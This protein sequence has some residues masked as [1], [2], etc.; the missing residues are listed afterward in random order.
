MIGM[1]LSLGVCALLVSALLVRLLRPIAFHTGLVDHPDA[2]RLHA[3]PTPAIGGVAIFIVVILLGLIV[4]PLTPR[5]LGL[6]LAALVVVIAGVVDDHR[7]LGWRKRMIFQAVAGLI[8]AVIAGLR[9]TDLGL[10][11]GAPVHL[12]L[13]VSLLLT[14]IATVGTI[15]AINMI[16][17][18]DGLAGSASLVTLLMLTG[19][20]ASAGDHALTANFAVT[21]G[22]VG[23]FLVFNIR[24]PGT[25]RA[26]VFL[27]NAGAE[28][29]GLLLVAACLRLTQET[30]H[31]LPPKIAPFLLA[32]ALID[33]LTVII[34][35]VRR[36]A[37]PFRAG[38]DHLHEIL[39]DAGLSVNGVVALVS[40]VTLAIG[41]LA[42]LAARA[43]VPDGGFTL[44]FF[45]LWL[46]YG[47]AARPRRT[48]VAGRADVAA[49]SGA[50][51][52]VTPCLQTSSL[53]DDHAA[54]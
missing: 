23:G 13:I 38:R 40:V 50:P 12:P 46:A 49:T 36:G 1:A 44:A 26:S 19:V 15:N 33:C 48:G 47:L 51:T 22:A 3:A 35:R 53:R 32:P 8:L 7:R 20:A 52:E 4:H 42:L 5:F 34:R 14:V 2:R 24:W 6:D 41:L 10:I 45:G 29:L 17:G 18:V 39:L 30:S 25:S 11:L 37:S 16:D 9:V 31:P 27:G 43:R 28:L 54:G 21:A